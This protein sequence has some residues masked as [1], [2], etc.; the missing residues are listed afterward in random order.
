[1]NWVSSSNPESTEAAA[2]E[3]QS[4]RRF[5]RR[6][7]GFAFGVAVC[8]RVS[9][10]E[11]LIKELADSLP[12]LTFQTVRLTE[13][14]LDPL[15]EV[16]HQAGSPPPGPVMVVDFDRP[17]PSDQPDH[18]VLQALN[19]RRPEWPELAPQPV[20]FWVL[21]Y[22]LGLLGRE[23]PDFL[24][25]RSLT[26]FFPD[27]TDRELVALNSDAWD[28]GT[29]MSFRREER[30]AR[31]EELRSRLALAP[32]E[33]NDRRLLAAQSGWWN[34][35]GLHFRL[36]GSPKQQLA[37]FENAL[38]LARQ[39]G[40]R[41]LEGRFLGNIGNVY[42]GLGDTRKAIECYEFH[43][44]TARENGDRQREGISPRQPR[45]CI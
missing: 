37:C 19:L 24:D 33:T 13:Q 12:D 45:N 32:N 23:A 16:L 35:M 27:V 44:A 40:D 36:L 6:A 15:D 39:L 42:A 38:T 43:L 26:V 8:N 34:E 9:Q 1:M 7:G 14:T 10:R 18:P 4:L 2:E 11:A 5:V 41:Y 28:S 29:N 21:E 3:L 22:V 31:I 17:L 30:L 20:V 25:W